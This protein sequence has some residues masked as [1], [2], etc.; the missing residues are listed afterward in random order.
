M[1]EPSTATIELDDEGKPLAGVKAKQAAVDY[2]RMVL[3]Q[4]DDQPIPL[5]AFY[6]KFCERFAHTIRQ[7]V[8][9]NPKELLQFLKLNRNIFFIRSNKVCSSDFWT[10][11]RSP[12]SRTGP[13][14]TAQRMGRWTNRN[15]RRTTISS[16]WTR[17]PSIG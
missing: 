6:Q 8:A 15:R 3:E 17:T 1:P 11:R 5:D 4:N 13:R 9:T 2:L 10:T 12:W 14:R 16:P 7:D